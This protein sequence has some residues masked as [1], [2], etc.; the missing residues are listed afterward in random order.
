LGAVLEVL[1]RK[2]KEKNKNVFSEN[3]GLEANNKCFLLATNIRVEI[4]SSFDS[5]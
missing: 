4:E 1:S 2:L 3:Y 5:P